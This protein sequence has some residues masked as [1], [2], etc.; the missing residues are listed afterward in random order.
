MLKY[1]K[2][3]KLQQ[4]AKDIVCQNTDLS[5]REPLCDRIILEEIIFPNLLA[6][7]DPKKILDIGREEYESFYNDFFIGRELWT[8]DIDPKR[9][10]FGSKNHI[11]DNASNLKN[12]F[13]DGYFG[14]IIF[15]GVFGW[16]LNDPA[17][18]EKSIQ[19]M[20]DIMAPGGILVFGWNDNKDLTPVPLEDIAALKKFTPYKFPQ[21]GQRY[22][23][24]TGDHTYAFFIKK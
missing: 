12:H 20:Y 7:H 13:Q 3:R 21:L 10:R 2:R 17:E 8:I 4:Q 24:S 1:L 15:N 23:S 19:A 18:I 11:I 6:Y 14:A 5:E 9:R 16:G 22:L